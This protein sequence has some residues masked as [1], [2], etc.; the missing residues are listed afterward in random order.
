MK[1]FICDWCGSVTPKF[2]I[3]RF[4]EYY[5]DGDYPFVHIGRH[6]IKLHMCEY[7]HDRF[8]QIIIDKAR[9]EA[10]RL[11]NEN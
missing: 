4:Y 6:R 2:R 10:R 11:K 3:H 9:E 1:A 8:K 5:D 7:C